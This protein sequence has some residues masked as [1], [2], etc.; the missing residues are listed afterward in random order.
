M[1]DFIDA[2]IFAYYSISDRSLPNEELYQ[3]FIEPELF[4]TFAQHI[5]WLVLEHDRRCDNNG[6]LLMLTNPDDAD[7]RLNTTDIVALLSNNN[8][9]DNVHYLN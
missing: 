2:L 8:S 7:L 9:N 1:R 3:H 4:S 6:R 5:Y